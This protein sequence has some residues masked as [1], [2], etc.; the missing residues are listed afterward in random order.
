MIIK[1]ITTKTVI[2]S[3]EI[4]QK[5]ESPHSKK[6]KVNGLFSQ[7]KDNILYKTTA[8]KISAYYDLSFIVLNFCAN[9]CA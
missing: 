6:Q 5:F 8:H 2:H 1:Y 7:Y 4:R 9:L 3:S